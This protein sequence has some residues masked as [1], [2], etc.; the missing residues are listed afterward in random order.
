MPRGPFPVDPRPRSDPVPFSKF[1]F[2]PFCELSHVSGLFHFYHP[3]TFVHIAYRSSEIRLHVPR[4][5][6]GSGIIRCDLLRCPVLLWIGYKDR[7]GLDFAIGSL[8]RED[9]I[10]VRPV[11]ITQIIHQKPGANFFPFFRRLT[12]CCTG[13]RPVRLAFVV[14]LPRRKVFYIITFRVIIHITS[15]LS[16]TPSGNSSRI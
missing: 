12:V 1:A 3:K 13:F 9:F 8:R 16:I 11:G 14:Q 4:K 10:C 7:R 2:I 5:S 6:C 15:I